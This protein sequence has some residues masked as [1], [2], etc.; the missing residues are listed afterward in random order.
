MEVRNGE[1]GGGGGGEAW[2]AGYVVGPKRQLARYGLV[3]MH[4]TTSRAPINPSSLVRVGRGGVAWGYLKCEAVPSMRV[5][6]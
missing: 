1:G 3:G 5:V 2:I 4:G 6:A